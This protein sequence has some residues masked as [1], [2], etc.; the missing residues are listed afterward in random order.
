MKQQGHTSIYEGLT[1]FLFKTG[2][3]ACHYKLSF[4]DKLRHPAVCRN[5]T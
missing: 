5:T 4:K 3:S 2:Q 1:C